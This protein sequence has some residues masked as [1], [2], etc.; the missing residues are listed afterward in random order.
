MSTFKIFGLVCFALILLFLFKGA[1]ETESNDVIVS[2]PNSIESVVDT[3]V[4]ALQR[5]SKLVVMTARLNSIGTSK[6]YKMGMTAEQ[7]DIATFE[8]RYSLDLNQINNKNFEVKDKVMTVTLP[9]IK[10]E[11]VRKVKDPLYPDH[12]RYDNA[13]ILF[14]LDSTA[15]A[16]TKNNNELIKKDLEKQ[17]KALIPQAET[18]ASVVIQPMIEMIV[19]SSGTKNIQVKVK[20]S[21]N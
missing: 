1:G 10:S 15:E 18:T 3:S 8:V 7:T 20:P 14:S 12:K 9:P 16:L 21:N 13:S 17:S 4:S 5:Q 6:M 2:A 19:K 11:I